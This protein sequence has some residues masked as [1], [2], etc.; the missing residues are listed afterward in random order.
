MKRKQPAFPQ[1][2]FNSIIY[3]RPKEKSIL[4][5]NNDLSKHDDCS[6]D[7]CNDAPQLCDCLICRSVRDELFAIIGLSPN[8]D[9]DDLLDNE[10]QQ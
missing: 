4:P 1:A 6:C 10:V 7:L 8:I 9:D 3:D 5:C 2:V